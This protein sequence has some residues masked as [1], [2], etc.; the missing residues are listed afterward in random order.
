MK[1]F[2]EKLKKKPNNVTDWMVSSSLESCLNFNFARNMNTEERVIQ[3]REI[4]EL[5]FTDKAKAF[6]LLYESYYLQLTVY[7]VQLTDSFSL[8]EDLVQDIFVTL[9]EKE[10]WKRIKGSLR[11]YLFYSV[12][13]NAFAALRRHKLQS[14]EE[15]SDIPCNPP[16]EIYDVNEFAEQQRKLMKEFEQL[17]LRESEAIRKVI[18]ENKKYKEA[19]EELQISVNTLKTHLGRALSKLKKNNNL[20]FFFY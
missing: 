20:M 2:I 14:I 16:D 12:R 5:F 13:N 10:L 3:D 4:L 6:K 17:P 1:W 7:A 11:N 9:W 15:L 18:L 8:S 19:A